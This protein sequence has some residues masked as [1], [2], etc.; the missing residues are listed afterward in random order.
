MGGQRR[1]RST[2]P[3]PPGPGCPGRAGAAVRKAFSRTSGQR[4]H[5]VNVHEAAPGPLVAAV[6]GAGD[7]GVH[8]ARGS[9]R[10]SER[11]RC[12]GRCH[13]DGARGLSWLRQ[14]SIKSGRVRRGVRAARAGRN[15][16]QGRS[17][18]HAAASKQPERASLD[19]AVPAVR[20][21]LGQG[22]RGAHLHDAHLDHVRGVR[23]AHAAPQVDRN[24]GPNPNPKPRTSMMP[25]S[26]T[27]ATCARHCP[28]GS[29]A[30]N[31]TQWI[32]SLHRSRSSGCGRAWMEG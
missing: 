23:Q 30:L 22:L 16:R 2:V 25:I 10:A 28:S 29:L 1:E 27:P 9:R 31:S 24:P 14:P 8:L 13:A 17:A 19:V 6:V 12:R 26:T 7:A 5:V 4:V 20:K 3:V 18:R 32:H 15:Q 11:M 21:A